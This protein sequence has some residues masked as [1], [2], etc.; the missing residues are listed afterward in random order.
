LDAATEIFRVWELPW[1]LTLTVTAF[2]LIYWRGWRAIRQ[3]RA[4]Q[5]PEWRLG[6]FLG[7]MAVLWVSIASPID[8]FADVLLSAHMVEHL[9]LMSAVP[10][11]ICLS[12]PIVPLLRGLPR[13]WVRRV[14]RPLFRTGLV[15]R[16]GHFFTLPVVAWLVFNLVFVLWHVPSAY[17]FA[18]ENEHVHDFE[19]L[20]FL[21]AS[22]L[23]WWPVIEPWPAR[24]GV[25]RWGVLPY[26]MTADLVN[27]ALSAVL[28]FCDRPVYTYYLTHPN[29]FGVAP[30]ADQQLGAVTMWV[31][32]SVI[33]LVPVVVLT[34]RMMQPRRFGRA[35]VV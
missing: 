9:L 24:Q 5:F 12:A 17:D 26:L 18:L 11:L 28:A 6:C 20:C 31:L 16:L 10:P 2:C 34:W 7:G 4:A 21:G 35:S 32:G 14:L 1:G 22:L 23:F 19:H 3:T 30:L 15:H 29:P 33:F 27:T 8:G 13:V 25:M